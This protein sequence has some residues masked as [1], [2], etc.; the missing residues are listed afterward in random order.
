[1]CQT[2]NPSLVHKLRILH[3]SSDLSSEDTKGTTV[4]GKI[5]ATGGGVKKDPNPSPKKRR[6]NTS[7]TIG[8]RYPKGELSQKIKRSVLGAFRCYGRPQLRS[9]ECVPTAWFSGKPDRR[10]IRER[11]CVDIPGGIGYLPVEGMNRGRRE[12]MLI[13]HTRKQQT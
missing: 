8:V 11:P 4:V 13:P 9:Y 12:D 10:W 5:Q 1:M 7:Y 3:C 6:T 2:E